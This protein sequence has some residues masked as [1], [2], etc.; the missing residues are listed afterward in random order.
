[1]NTSSKTKNTLIAIILSVVLMLAAFLTVIFAV[2]KGNLSADEYNY[3]EF[4]EAG[5]YSLNGVTFYG[6]KVRNSY[7]ISNNK[8]QIADID[9]IVYPGEIATQ[10]KY[11]DQ[12]GSQ[13]IQISN[14]EFEIGNKKYK[15]ED[16][17]VKIISSSGA[18]WPSYEIVMENGKPAIVKFGET[19]LLKEDEAIML[20]FARQTDDGKNSGL[21]VDADGAIISKPVD[22]LNATIKVDGKTGTDAVENNIPRVEGEAYNKELGY[23]IDP[24]G[25]VGSANGKLGVNSGNEGK[26][27]FSTKEYEIEGTLQNF[28]F[29]FYVFK[30]STYRRTE[31]VNTSQPF[32]RPDTEITATSHVSDPTTKQDYYAEYFYYYQNQDLPYLTFDPTRFE[33]TIEK[34]VHRTSTTYTFAFDKNATSGKETVLNTKVTKV[35]SEISG[36]KVL[37]TISQALSTMDI[38]ARTLRVEEEHGTGRIRVYFEDLGDYVITYRAVYHDNDEKVVLTNLN[39]NSRAD[40]LS[41]FGTELTYQDYINGQSPLR[42]KNNTFFADLTGILGK[43][44]NKF[45]EVFQYVNVDK[46][47]FTLANIEYEIKYTDPIPAKANQ[48][49]Y[50]KIETISITDNKFTI[51]GVEYQIKFLEGS[52]VANQLTYVEGEEEKTITITDNKFTLNDIEYEIKYTETDPANADQLTYTKIE[53]ISI[54]NNIFK[55]GEI[56][57]QIKFAEE[58]PSL[59][60]QITYTENGEEKTISITNNK[61]KIGE[62][63]YE[64]KYSEPIPAIAKQVAYTENGEEKTTITDNEFTI[65]GVKYQIKFSSTEPATATQLQYSIGQRLSLSSDILIASTNQPPIKLMFNAPVKGFE[66]YFSQTKDG[67]FKTLANVSY[68]SNFDKPGF[69]VVKVKTEF[70]NYKSWIGASNS[71]RTETLPTEQIYAFQIKQ[72]TSNLQ[73]YVLGNDGEPVA[74]ADRQR[75]YSD[76]YVKNGVQIIEFEKANE[77]DSQIYFEIVKQ[78]YLQTS[79][80]AQRFT[81]PNESASELSAEQKQWLLSLGI[82]KIDSANGSYYILK[83]RENVNVDGIYSLSLKFGKSGKETVSF[84]L[85]TEQIN[86]ISSYS[87]T[88]TTGTE[89]FN[90]KYLIG[91]E[92][93]I[94]LTNMPFTLL[95][96]NKKSGAKIT[97]KFVRFTIDRKLF[98]TDDSAYIL[99]S[100]WL[101]ADYAISLSESNPETLYEKA[102]NKNQVTAKSVLSLSG[103]YI[104]SLEDEAGNKAYYSVVVDNSVS[105]VLQKPTNS[106]DAFKKIPGVNNVSEATTIFFGSHKAIQFVDINGKSITDESGIWGSGKLTPAQKY[107]SALKNN[108]AAYDEKGI[109]STCDGVYFASVPIKNVYYKTNGEI[110]A[111]SKEQ[112]EQGYYNIAV[113]LDPNTNRLLDVTY[114]FQIFDESNLSKNSPTTS[115]AVRFNTDATGLL[116]YTESG[117]VKDSGIQNANSRTADDYSYR[118]KYYKVTDASVAYLTWDNLMPIEELNAVVDIKNGGLVCR[119]YPLVYN[120]ETNSYEY[121]SEYTE[122][123]LALEG[124][125]DEQLTKGFNSST[126]V[127]IPLNVVNGKTQAGR[128]EIIRKYSPYNTPVLGDLGS[129]FPTIQIV[130]FVD[131]NEII[132]PENVNGER[133]GFYTYITTFDGGVQGNKEFFNELYRQA[134]GSNNYVIQTNQLPIGFYIPVAKYGTVRKLSNGILGEVLSLKGETGVQQSNISDILFKESVLFTGLDVNQQL[135]L[136]STYSPF[137]FRIVLVS[138][139]TQIKDGVVENVYYYYSLNR[140]GYYMLSGYSIGELGLTEQPTPIANAQAFLN[141]SLT[142]AQYATGNYELRIGCVSNDATNAYLQNF[143]VIVNVYAQGPEY[144]MDAE[145]SDLENMESRDISSEN[146]KD[147]WTNSNEIRVSWTKPSNSYLTA[148]DI[149]Q[150]SYTYSIGASR[151]TIP[152]ISNAEGIMVVNGDEKS[153]FFKGA[154]IS[155][156]LD[157][158]ENRYY[159]EEGGEKSFLS[160]PIVVT[161]NGNAFTFVASFPKEA[162]S[163]TIEMNYETYSVDTAKYYRPYYPN[164]L[165]KETKNVY[166]D[167]EAPVSSIAELKKNDK[168]I[169]G[170]VDQLLRESSDSRFSKSATTGMFAFYTYKANKNYFINLSNTLSSNPLTETKTFYY[171]A[172]N[173]KYSAAAFKETGI[174]YDKSS[175]GDNLFSEYFAEGNGWKKVSSAL[176]EETIFEDGYYEIVELDYSGNA[177]IYSIYIGETRNIEISVDRKIKDVETGKVS[178]FK[179]VDENLVETINAEVSFGAQTDI[180]RNIISNPVIISSYDLLKLNWIS[181]NDLEAYAYL[182]LIIDNVVYILTPSNLENDGEKLVYTSLYTLLGEKV[183]LKDVSISGSG[184]SHTIAI[185]D[186]VNLISGAASTSFME[187]KVASSNARLTDNGGAIV[188]SDP[189]GIV[190]AQGNPISSSLALMVTTSLNP[191]LFVNTED[192]RIFK[193]SSNGSIKQYK[194]YDA[195]NPIYIFENVLATSK[196]TY[197]YIKAENDFATS[198]F[199]I[200]YKDNFDNEYKELVEYKA[201]S[202]NRFEGDLDLTPDSQFKNEILVS[203]PVAVNISNIYQVVLTNEN[204]G[205]VAGKFNKIDSALLG[206]SYTQ[207]QLLAPSKTS[208]SFAGGKITFKIDLRYNIPEEISN[209]IAGLYSLDEGNVIETIYVTIFNQLPVVKATDLNGEDISN[210]LF[211]KEINQSDPITLSF[212]SGNELSEAMGYTAKVFLRKRGD[213]S[214]YV[215]ITSPYVVSE[216]GV[217]DLYM[218]NFDADG[219]P[220]GYI[221]SKDFVISDLDVMF[222]TVTKTNS[223]GQQEV[224]DATGKVFEYEKGKFA[225]YHYIVNTNQFDVITNGAHVSKKLVYSSSNVSVY[226]ISSSSGTIYKATIAISVVDETN[227]ILASN[228]FIWFLGTTYSVPSENNYIRSTTKEIYLCADDIYNEISLRWASYFGIVENEITCEVSRDEGLTWTK[229]NPTTENGVSS[230]VLSKS[231]SYLFRFKDKAG[232]VQLFSSPSGYPSE[233]TKVNFIRSV[234]INVNGATAIDNA[235]YNGAVTITIPVNTTRFYSTT[236]IITVYRNNEPY[237]V[238]INAKGEYIFDEIG[239]YRV[240]FSAKVESGTRDLNE[241]VLTFTIINQNDS[242]WAFNYVNYNNYQ[243]KS[244]K[245]NGQE[246]SAAFIERMLEVENEINISAFD[247]DSLG[248]RWFENGVYT[249]TLVAADAT[250]SQTIEFSFWINNVTAPISVSLGE[251][252]STTG[253]V[254]IEYNRGNL[255]EILGDCYIQIDSKIIDV[256]DSSNSTESVPYTLGSVGEHYIQVYTSSGKL[257]YSY[258][259]QINEPLNTVSIILIVVS[260]VLVVAGLLTFLLLRKRMQVR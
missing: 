197:Y 96:N 49:T 126:P 237:S 20:C 157:Q 228:P 218:Q 19:I 208:S 145:Y 6:V 87:A 246:M 171:R 107:L 195:E 74:E 220:L 127:E 221:I 135:G 198:T 55:I 159:I 146:G 105:T 138:P 56:E 190:D 259:V 95:W 11:T 188:L 81:L 44:T 169:D 256:I 37:Q 114:N 147:F 108:L 155:P 110:T 92:G 253:T 153:F 94:G 163:L 88:E 240:Y 249:I 158:E 122:I 234:I 125:S 104:F 85:D 207:Y 33:V 5:Y 189:S 167:R 59:A 248:N 136:T 29:M 22:Y 12:T 64:I 191:A 245:F 9:E 204:G 124:L 140:N 72:Q 3:G 38:Y 213:D 70:G 97:A 205:S 17:K 154:Q 236:P 196:V 132:S 166:F 4:N 201:A 36:G 43:G 176:S 183:N 69:Y 186:T 144:K 180:H 68:T 86:G 24:N 51:D 172:F 53:K 82:E 141:G 194:L 100:T 242:R 46:N 78:G 173:N 187:A 99:N 90:T 174:G 160:F 231:S 116:I 13:T 18:Y 168:T 65:D 117:K 260:C 230:I 255:F 162:T 111:L 84:K 244:I 238:K 143:K 130:F 211:G 15:I 223:N 139:E 115:Y 206:G 214:H 252:E 254:T 60:I 193:I 133:V 151:T 83:P 226:E 30:E 106:S 61:F 178:I 32:V 131:R 21:I 120:K 203:G 2:K 1:M 156:L 28:S 216:P 164:A 8:F 57:Y 179:E 149:A 27:E 224:V 10:L 232:N 35:V 41:I 25:I 209:A 128:Y 137:E 26:V 45:E 185:V 76:N 215:E 184:T 119:F 39:E 250:G 91:E 177:T 202:F 251:G 48:L 77:F 54:D 112:V 89:F 102:E 217:Y 98:S 109:I 222:Y 239:T 71:A 121:S 75:I 150:I 58:D 161:Q 233:T 258:H 52:S 175:R 62:I 16:N 199:Y 14:G 200:L 210:A 165:Y 182:K 66:V 142:G 212:L 241:D 47:K 148:I 192:L 227:D 219:N 170:V 34:T 80:E 42:N 123:D 79:V 93:Q 7:S 129:D 225:S 31:T 40:K 113:P 73:L 103:L 23:F 257:V 243:I 63:E 67:E 50:A 229:A 235:I 181:F 152:S 134:Q 118:I 101:A 247:V